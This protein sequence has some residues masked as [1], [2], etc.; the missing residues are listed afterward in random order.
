M[1][2]FSSID[3]VVDLEFL[4]PVGRLWAD[5]R[6]FHLATVLGLIPCRLARMIRLS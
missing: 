6:F 4:G 1:M 2:A 5:V 3:N